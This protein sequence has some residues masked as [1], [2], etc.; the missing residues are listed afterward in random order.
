MSGHW[1]GEQI[2]PCLL[3]AGGFLVLGLFVFRRLED[4]FADAV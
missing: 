2:I 3:W 1:P 4:S